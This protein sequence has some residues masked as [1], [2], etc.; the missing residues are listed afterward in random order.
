MYFLRDFL[1]S[2]F[3]GRVVSLPNEL[4]LNYMTLFKRC[5]S[6]VMFSFFKQKYL[7]I[8]YQVTKNMFSLKTS[9]KNGNVGPDSPLKFKARF[10]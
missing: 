4:L 9:M 10:P 2:F 5:R 3:P 1:H 6:Q 7:E 8:L